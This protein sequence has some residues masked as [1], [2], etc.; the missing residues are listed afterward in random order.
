VIAPFRNR[1]A[2][3]VVTALDVKAP[4]DFASQIFELF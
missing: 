2:D 4:V 1:K 3:R